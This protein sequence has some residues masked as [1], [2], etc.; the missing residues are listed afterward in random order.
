M[1]LWGDVRANRG[2]RGTIRWSAPSFCR[3]RGLNQG[4]LLMRIAGIAAV[5]SL[6][7][8]GSLFWTP[9]QRSRPFDFA[10]GRRWAIAYRRA[11][12][13]VRRARPLARPRARSLDCDDC[14][15]RE[16][17]SSLGMTEIA[18]GTFP[19]ASL[20]VAGCPISR[21]SFAREVGVFPQLQLLLHPV[22]PESF[23]SQAGSSPPPLVGSE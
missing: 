3:Q 9:T 5:P 20:R 16:R 6:A 14:P 21:A 15:L 22:C 4:T 11:A 23:Y 7:G 18:C 8:L 10:Q 13:A 19:F 1:S 2:K 12:A 17:S